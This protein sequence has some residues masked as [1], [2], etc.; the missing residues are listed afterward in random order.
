MENSA[1]SRD[2]ATFR[3]NHGRSLSS[4]SDGGADDAEQSSA[5]LLTRTPPAASAES[6]PLHTTLFDEITTL[7][8]EKHF[9]LSEKTLTR[10][11]KLARAQQNVVNTLRL[12][13]SPSTIVQAMDDISCRSVVERVYPALLPFFDA[14]KHGPSKG[15]VCRGCALY[16]TGGLYMDID[17]LTVPRSVWLIA[18]GLRSSVEGKT[19]GPQRPGGTKARNS[20]SEAGGG[21]GAGET[22][23]RGGSGAGAPGFRLRGSAELEGGGHDASSRGGQKRRLAEDDP[24]TSDVGQPVQDPVTSSGEGPITS[25]GEGTITSSGEGPVTSSGEG[26]VTS[27]GEGTKTGGSSRGG[28]ARRGAPAPRGDAAAPRPLAAQEPTDAQEPLAPQEPTDE[29]TKQAGGGGGGRSSEEGGSPAGRGVGGP[30][31]KSAGR[32]EGARKSADAED[33]VLANGGGGKARRAGAAGSRGSAELV[34]GN[35]SPRASAAKHSS[36]GHQDAEVVPATGR[37]D[38]EDV[39]SPAVPGG[40]GALAPPLAPVLPT[41]E[42]PSERDHAPRGA[43][44]QH[45]GRSAEAPADKLQ[46]VV[47]EGVDPSPDVAEERH[48]VDPSPDVAEER[49]GVDPSPDVAEERHG[50]GPE[51]RHVP[52]EGGRGAL[53]PML[54]TSEHQP[55]KDRGPRGGGA[56]AHG[57]HPAGGGGGGAPADKPQQTVVEQVKGVDPRGPDVAEGRHQDGGGSEDRHRTGDDGSRDASREERHEARRGPDVAEERGDSRG[58]PAVPR[59]DVPHHR[60]EPAVPPTPRESPVHAPPPRGAPVHAPP[61]PRAAPVVEQGPQVDPHDASIDK[62]GVD[63]RP[64]TVR[65]TGR[66]KPPVSASRGGGAHPPRLA[67]TDSST[68]APADK[69]Q[70]TVVEQ[71]ARVHRPDV[72]RAD[73][74]EGR[75]GEPQKAVHRAPPREGKESSSDKLLVDQAPHVVVLDPRLDDAATAKNRPK[76]TRTTGRKK[77]PPPAASCGAIP[78][79]PS[80]RTFR[81]FWTHLL[82]NSTQFVT[83]NDAGEAP[84]FFQAFWGVVKKDKVVRRYLDY[85]LAYYKNEKQ[86]DETK[87]GGG[88]GSG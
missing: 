21:G 63:A 48:G 69:P 14:E 54:S 43:P 34:G 32:E 25:S 29:H 76:T 72:D 57:G 74:A 62:A 51:D 85:W 50:G 66:K 81:R 40:A 9:A 19:G 59:G 30:P 5:R 71:A 56:P 83:V 47:V 73:V 15:D 46:Q 24:V 16:E 79:Q 64:K 61:P 45:G 38:A 67:E 58:E 65:T 44:A 77:P 49:H 26:P 2:S 12:L 78:E 37:Q 84:T 39:E 36:R 3:R 41:S 52:R 20:A 4:S 68:A 53:A 55:E 27:S 75:R 8:R 35:A 11:I 10:L 1:N 7:L 22:K 88:T 31:P 60:G 80:V 42:H 17:L 18:D 6:T 87:I 33:E 82:R 70:Q 13:G 86:V 23:A 28:S